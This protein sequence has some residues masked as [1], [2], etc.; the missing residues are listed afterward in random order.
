MGRGEGEGGERRERDVTLNNDGVST[1]QADLRGDTLPMYPPCFCSSNR[2]T[3]VRGSN[4]DGRPIPP[5][6]HRQMQALRCTDQTKTFQGL[7][8]GQHTGGLSFL[9]ASLPPS[10]VGEPGAAPPVV[11]RPGQHGGREEHPQ[12][13]VERLRRQVKGDAVQI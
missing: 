11:G 13:E 3:P 4:T 9:E 7:K 12:E 8:T 6:A 2:E 1:K 10:S 5:P